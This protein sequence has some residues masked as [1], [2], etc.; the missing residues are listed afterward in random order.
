MSAI[1][2]IPVPSRQRRSPWLPYHSPPPITCH[3]DDPSVEI[4]TRDGGD[5][6]EQKRAGKHSSAVKRELTR[7]DMIHWPCMCWGAPRIEPV[8]ADPQA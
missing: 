3:T 1:E 2:D 8:T 5:G 4:L 7:T 6:S